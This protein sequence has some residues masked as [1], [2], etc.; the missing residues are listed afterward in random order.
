MDAMIPSF[1]LTDARLRYTMS[2]P[3]RS[4]S[5]VKEVIYVPYSSGRPAGNGLRVR[6]T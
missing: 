3:S 5:P 6:F 4:L 1:R 2:F